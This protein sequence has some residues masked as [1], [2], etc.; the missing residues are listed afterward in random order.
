[1]VRQQAQPRDQRKEVGMA[2]LDRNSLFTTIDRVNQALF[3]GTSLT[4]AEKTG[5]ARWIAGLRGL[6]G[7]YAGMFAPVTGDRPA[8]VRSFTGERLIS[9][10]RTRHVL[11]EE[12]CRLLVLLD[13]PDP[14]VQDALSRAAAGMIEWLRRF[15]SDGHAAGLFC[16]GT[17]SGA[18]WRHV[19]AGG[20]DRNEE[21]LS[22]AVRDLKASR[23]G[24]SHW[25]RFPFYYTLLALNE[26][27]TSGAL[28]EMRYAGPVLERYVRTSSGR[29]AYSRRKR[30]LAT[31]I[32]E[33]L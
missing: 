4:D 28:E 16:C 15:E 6:P 18:Y 21:R 10:A 2:L 32:L 3:D 24:D 23:T 31:K 8:D 30:A 5:V 7:S 27:G 26:M 11:G 19:A 29:D 12:A 17:C 33:K 9:R 25:G 1:M 20:L 14:G 13:V 22:A